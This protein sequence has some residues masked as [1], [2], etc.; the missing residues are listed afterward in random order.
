MVPVPA[1]R[2][3]IERERPLS[4]DDLDDHDHRVIVSGIEW[5]HF[6]SIL[7][8]HADRPGTRLAYLDGDLDLTSPSLNH[9]R[10]KTLV[11]RLLEAYADELELDVD[12]Y[13][14][15]TLKDR[16]VAAALEPDE[17]YAIGDTS[18]GGPRRPD[19]A[20]DIDI[21]SGGVDRMEIYRRLGVREVWRWRHGV[22]AVHVLG[23]K[24]Y[25][26]RTDSSVLP[27]FDTGA[28]CTFLSREG[29]QTKIV[30]AWRAWLRDRK[31]P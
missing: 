2:R 22:I 23:R 9:E 24:G 19:L 30:R 17:C 13:G 21:T 26:L 3:A 14:S 10:R 6:E 16:E 18:P 15:W 7:D 5:D 12:G 31:Q 11:G 8:R 27:G 28:L 20:I 25:K 1:T 4:L 29:S